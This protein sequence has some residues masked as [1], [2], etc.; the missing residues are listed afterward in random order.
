MLQA[1]YETAISVP[2]VKMFFS[3][4]VIGFSVRKNHQIIQ[5]PCRLRAT[6]CHQ[7]FLFELSSCAQLTWDFWDC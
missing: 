4:R 6:A 1:T 2:S 7:L 5:F 3:P